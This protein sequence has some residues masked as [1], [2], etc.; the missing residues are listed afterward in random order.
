[1]R[2]YIKSTQHYY[3]IEVHDTITLLKYE[4]DNIIS[5]FANLEVK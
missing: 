3:I 5:Q 2:G 4:K 1:M